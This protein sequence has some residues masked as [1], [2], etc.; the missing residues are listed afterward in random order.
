[1]T[2]RDLMGQNAHWALTLKEV[3][4]DIV[5][6]E[7]AHIVDENAL[8][9]IPRP[10]DADLS[11]TRLGNADQGRAAPQAVSFP[12]NDAL[13]SLEDWDPPEEHTKKRQLTP[14]PYT[15][16]KPTAVLAFDRNA[17]W[18]TAPQVALATPEAALRPV[19]PKQ[20]MDA[21]GPALR[22]SAKLALVASLLFTPLHRRAPQSCTHSWSRT[23]SIPI[24][25]M[26]SAASSLSDMRFRTPAPRSTRRPRRCKPPRPLRSCVVQGEGPYA[27][28]RLLGC[29]RRCVGPQ[30]RTPHSPPHMNDDLGPASGLPPPCRGT[31]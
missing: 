14:P 24:Q 30:H 29:P 21:E 8:S 17:S 7:G 1:M 23:H 12:D 28:A 31:R 18:T 10:Q 9:R 2:T 16:A 11:G 19:L 13:E 25:Q 5:H 27:S 26:G 6:R 22:G 4:S 3:H 15:A 20:E